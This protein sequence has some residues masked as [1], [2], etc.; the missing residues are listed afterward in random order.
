MGTVEASGVRGSS[1]I[2]YYS[3][4]LC[5]RKREECSETGGSRKT[6]AVLNELSSRRPV[7]EWALIQQAAETFPLPS[8]C[9]RMTLELFD[10]RLNNHDLKI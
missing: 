7:A 4:D 3:I 1:E 8:H 10:L 2:G 9:A 5:S 6:E